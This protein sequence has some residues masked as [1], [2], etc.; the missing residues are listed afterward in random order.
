M[1]DAETAKDLTALA[2]RPREKSLAIASR[3]R[4]K[5][6]IRHQRKRRDHL[7]DASGRNRHPRGPIVKWMGRIERSRVIAAVSRL[8]NAF[9]LKRGARSRGQDRAP[10]ARP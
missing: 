6:R 3:Q 5:F 4:I 7:E 10:F 9:G 2:I 1:P 8:A